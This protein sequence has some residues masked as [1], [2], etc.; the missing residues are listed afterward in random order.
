MPTHLCFKKKYIHDKQEKK[1][2]WSLFALS[3]IEP[4]K[5]LKHFD[6]FLWEQLTVFHIVLYFCYKN[7]THHVS[8]KVRCWPLTY[9]HKALQY[10]AGHLAFK[11]F[12]FTSFHSVSELTSS[13]MLTQARFIF[14]FDQ[15]ITDP[16]P[17]I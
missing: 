13:G 5:I 1:G 14:P 11:C 15:N 4:I 12:S 8:E 17:T 6:D 9:L 10:K 2:V 3:K 7:K 16:K